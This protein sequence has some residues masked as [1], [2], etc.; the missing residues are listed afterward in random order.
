MTRLVPLY[1]SGRQADALRTYA[2]LRAALLDEL[3]ID[4]SP[5]LRDLEVS[6]LQQAAEL[7]A[8]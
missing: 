4:P 7:D 8:D 1:R 3:G 6:I 5:A 2:D